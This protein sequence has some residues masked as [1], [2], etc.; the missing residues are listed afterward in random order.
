[1]D[2]FFVNG[3]KKNSL[4]DLIKKSYFFSSCREGVNIMF[5]NKLSS[6]N[7]ISRTGFEPVT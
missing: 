1:M 6:K 7:E 3:T 4:V 2:F 5:K